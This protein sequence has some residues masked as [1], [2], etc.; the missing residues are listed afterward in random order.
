[1]KQLQGAS[2]VLQSKLDQ[3]YIMLTKCMDFPVWGYL[4]FKFCAFTPK[5]LGVLKGRLIKEWDKLSL[6]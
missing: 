4:Q 1:M 2:Q 3:V 5:N 6:E